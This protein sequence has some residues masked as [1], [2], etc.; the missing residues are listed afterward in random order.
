MSPL[1]SFRGV[2]SLLEAPALSPVFSPVAHFLTPL[3]TRPGE[4]TG[5][6]LL[7]SCLPLFHEG[8]ITTS[9][10]G[11]PTPS[12]LP[13]VAHVSLLVDLSEQEHCRGAITEESLCS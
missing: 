6:T 4:S 12:P 10:A 1:G 2:G 13:G 5:A 11:D 9:G 7:L 8:L 3:E